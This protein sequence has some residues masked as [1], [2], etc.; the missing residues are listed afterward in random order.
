MLNNAHQRRYMRMSIPTK[1]SSFFVYLGGVLDFFSIFAHWESSP[2][3]RF[4]RLLNNEASEPTGTEAIMFLRGCKRLG[5]ILSHI[6][7]LIEAFQ[8][9]TIGPVN[10]GGVETGE[11]D[12]GGG[13]A[14]MSH[15]L[16]DYGQRYAFGFGC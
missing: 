16:R 15:T 14:V 2:F 7:V 4:G 12:L 5:V 1:N 3:K 13:L 11:I 6:A 9:Q 8:N 10:Y